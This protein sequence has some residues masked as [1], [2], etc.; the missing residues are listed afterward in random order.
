MIETKQKKLSNFLAKQLGPPE[1]YQNGQGAEKEIGTRHGIVSF[2]HLHG[3][4]DN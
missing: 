3:P 1:K 4:T 2:F